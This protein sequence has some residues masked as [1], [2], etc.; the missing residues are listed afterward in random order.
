MVKINQNYIEW[1]SVTFDYDYQLIE[2]LKS[3][4]ISAYRKYNP[5][6][7]V[8]LIH[9]DVLHI[10]IEYL[11][12]H[13][14]EFEYEISDKVQEAFNMTFNNLVS[15]PLYNHQQQG[16][17]FLHTHKNSIIGDDQGLGKTLE[18]ITFAMSLKP[19]CKHVL[20][21]C[22]VA[23]NVWNWKYEIEKHTNEKA[24]I[25]GQ[26][27]SGNIG[28][29]DDKLVALA[30]HH[31]E[32][33]YIMN[34]ESLRGGSHKEGR[35]R[36]YPMAEAIN[37]LTYSDEIGCICVDECHKVKNP[38]SQ[39]G[40]ALLQLKAKRKV[41]MSGTLVMNNPLDLYVPLRWC[42]ITG[43]TYY[44]FKNNYIRYGGYGGYEVL[45]Y[46]NQSHLKSLLSPIFLRRTKTEVLDLPEKIYTKEIIQ[47]SSQ[48]MTGYNHIQNGL[49]DE[50]NKIFY[51]DNPLSMMLQ[52]RMYLD[53]PS[54]QSLDNIKSPKFER[55]SELLENLFEYQDTKVIIYSQWATITRNMRDYLADKY[56]CSYIEG[57]VAVDKRMH[58]IDK[59]QSGETKIIIGTIGAM[60]T[61]FTLNTATNVIFLDEPWNRALKDQAIDRAHRIGTKSTVNVHTLICKDTIDERIH[62][63]IDDK[64][65]ISD[66]LLSVHNKKLSADDIKYLLGM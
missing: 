41:M 45:G 16:I 6:T 51:S 46:K 49:R 62:K 53:D 32:Y 11:K 31:D 27:K 61:G 7:Q 38:E 52:L 18:F 1:V 21:I 58:E 24:Y 10:L 39:I 20:I 65:K 29:T 55:V 47:L 42:N 3:N 25:I 9:K 2:W 35:T 22:G 4:I 14:I 56:K 37:K 57:D 40:K 5:D 28:T 23:G 48:Q 34:I 60:G 63:L 30:K 13:D 64:G 44:R 54:S 26:K 15:T 36:V 66:D 59:F 50:I 33:F 17:H 12:L 43:D 8:W 19:T